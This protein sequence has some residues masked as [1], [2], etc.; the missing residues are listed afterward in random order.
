MLASHAP[1]PSHNRGLWSGGCLAACWGRPQQDAAR[2][3]ARRGAVGERQPAIDEQRDDAAGGHGRVE[4][5]G[6]RRMAIGIEH[7]EIGLI[8]GRR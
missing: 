6:A 8:P 5:V 7:D 1:P 4:I 2:R 3:H